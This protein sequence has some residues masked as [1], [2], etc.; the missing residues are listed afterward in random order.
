MTTVGGKLDDVYT[1]TVLVLLKTSSLLFTVLV[2]YLGACD[3]FAVMNCCIE[4]VETK[5]CQ[6]MKQ[7]THM[8]I[9]THFCS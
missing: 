4:G 7:E 3:Q 9:D 8:Y 1:S 5:R 2:T 6:N